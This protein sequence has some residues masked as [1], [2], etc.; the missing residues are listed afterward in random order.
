MKHA[1][2]AD[3]ERGF[4]RNTYNNERYALISLFSKYR[5]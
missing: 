1:I 3:K 4:N 2:I 5:N